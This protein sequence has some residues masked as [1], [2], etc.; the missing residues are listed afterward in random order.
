MISH[1]MLN[2]GIMAQLNK[3]VFFFNLLKNKINKIVF[4]ETEIVDHS[5]QKGFELKVW[6]FADCWHLDL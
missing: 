2:N 3:I 5:F 1:F 4:N 6:L